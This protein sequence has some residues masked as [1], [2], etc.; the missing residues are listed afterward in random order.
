MN[1][2]CEVCDTTP[3]EEK[4]ICIFLPSEEN[5]FKLHICE[6]SILGKLIYR[7]KNLRARIHPA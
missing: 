4:K 3:E 1:F 5:E 7:E 6:Y 2:D